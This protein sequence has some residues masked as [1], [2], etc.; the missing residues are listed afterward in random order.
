MGSESPTLADT[1]TFRLHHIFFN[2][3]FLVLPFIS[4]LDTLRILSTTNTVLLQSTEFTVGT[5]LSSVPSG[6]IA[7]T[8]RNH[9]RW[10]TILLRT[11]FNYNIRNRPITGTTAGRC[12]TTASSRMVSSLV[13]YLG[14]SAWPPD[15][16]VPGSRIRQWNVS[17][18]M[19]VDR[20]KYHPDAKYLRSFA[21]L[22]A[23]CKSA[24]HVNPSRNQIYSK[25]H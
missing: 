19:M 5:S 11:S 3:N 4:R 22:A 21:A 7:F 24:C 25:L 23:D 8:F 10:I 12:G 15:S 14:I 20:R 17:C 9:F 18:R 2:Y 16:F 13:N 6:W 1:R